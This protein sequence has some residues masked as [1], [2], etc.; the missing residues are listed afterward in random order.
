MSLRSGHLFD[1]LDKAQIMKLEGIAKMA[2]V[3]KGQV[4]FKDGS[5]DFFDGAKDLFKYYF[6]L[7]KYKPK[8][9]R[10][11]I[12]AIYAESWLKNILTE[13]ST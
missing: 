1:G 12:E 10:A 5:V 13:M 4:I 7:K 3:E 8:K 9:T 11:D 2:Q 6:N